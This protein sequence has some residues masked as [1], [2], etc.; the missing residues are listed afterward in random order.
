MDFR[1][2]RI[3]S[4]TYLLLGL[5]LV[6]TGQNPAGA[7]SGEF[8]MCHSQ[9][10]TPASPKLIGV[11]KPVYFHSANGVYLVSDRPETLTASFN[12]RHIIAGQAIAQYLPQT[13]SNGALQQNQCFVSYP[14]FN[15]DDSGKVTTYG[16]SFKLAPIS[17]K[18]IQ[19]WKSLPQSNVSWTTILFEPDSQDPKLYHFVGW[20]ENHQ[21]SFFSEET[22]NGSV[23]R[24]SLWYQIKSAIPSRYQ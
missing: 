7:A 12:R 6:V 4:K 10:T 22:E 21:F 14:S 3:L 5:V 8:G 11:L 15:D 1:S 16:L 24:R 23:N 2:R 18:V 19:F 9:Q 13:L 17:S 20:A